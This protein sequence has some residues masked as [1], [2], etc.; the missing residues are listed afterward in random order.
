MCSIIFVSLAQ[1]TR[2]FDFKEAFGMA[3]G[4]GLISEKL[5]NQVIR[6]VQ[7]ILNV[8]ELNEV[9][10]GSDLLKVSKVTNTMPT[11]LF[12]RPAGTYI[13]SIIGNEDPTHL[14]Y[15][16]N[17]QGIFG[18]AYSSPFIFRNLS[19]GATS[20]SWDWGTSIH[21][22]QD[23]NLIIRTN[24]SNGTSENYLTKGIYYSPK[25]N[26]INGVDT[27]KY[28][29]ASTITA[30]GIYGPFISASSSSKYVSNADYYGNASIATSN[31]THT[32]WLGASGSTGLDGTGSGYYWG[33]CLR[34]TDGINGTKVNSIVT[35][36]EKPMSPMVIKDVC[37]SGAS[38]K[39][40]P[41]PQNKFLTLTIY[42]IDES[43]KITNEVLASSKIYGSDI[44]VDSY[45]NCFFP[46]TFLEIDP[47]TGREA[48]MTLVVKDPFALVLSGLE[49][50]GCD[51]G[52]ISDRDNKIEGT[53]YFTKVDALTGISDG[54]LYNSS[55]K[56]NTYMM[57]NAYFNYLHADPS[58]QT[59]TVPA[60]GGEAVDAKGISGSLVYSYF[61][62]TNDN[63][64]G[65]SIW[66]E[67]TTLPSW[68]TISHD[69]SIY[70]KSGALVFTCTATALQVGTEGRSADIV[71]KSFGA[72]TTLHIL[73]GN[74]TL[75]NTLIKTTKSKVYNTPNSFE[76]SYP[77]EFNKVTLLN[78]SGQV[79][80]NY[81]LTSTGRFSINT[82]NISAGIYI[83][84]LT[85]K[86]TETFKV[87]R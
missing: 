55:V 80:C 2:S 60:T 8:D 66:V 27:A 70:A 15:S 73:Q 29:P 67:P 56:M 53:S 9:K 79:V 41:V 52:L 28:M 40:I 12:N 35:V 51:F 57:L 49:Q 32:W 47:V 77:V 85:G 81:N 48:A 50:D 83:L 3:D 87:I 11:A 13:P 31:G 43:G 58:T 75:G 68:L 33:T 84:K 71:I 78:L 22:S 4:N 69:N 5:S 10:A 19:V 82:S 62:L 37:I 16:Y 45:N 6:P 20:Y 61:N 7:A 36:Y 86:E 46:F 30:D 23:V 24:Y 74:V 34:P 17:S 18:S 14:G 63:N 1:T 39:K 59:I 21:F 54:K 25:L 42:R 72:E 64:S 76:L 26:A 65:D 44:I 38:G